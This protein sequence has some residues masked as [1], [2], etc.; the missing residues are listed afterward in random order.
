MDDKLEPIAQRMRESKALV[1][2]NANEIRKENDDPPIGL[3]EKQ[4]VIEAKQTILNFSVCA[5]DGGLLA[6]R[7]VGA[8]ILVRRSVAVN[9]IYSNGLLSPVKYHP[10]KFPDSIVDFKS[11]L[12]EHDALVFR[13]LFR[14]RGEIGLAIEALDIFKPNFLFLDGSIVPLGSDKPGEGSV[15]Y[16]DYEE[17][18]KEYKTLYQK[19][20]TS[21]CQ[22]VGVIKD[23]RG[24]RLVE[25]LADQLM[26]EFP[27]S[28]LCDALL[29]EGER[30]SIMSYSADVKKHQVLKSLGDFSER[31]KLFYLKP[32]SID[33]PLR[34]EFLQNP[35]DKNKS[36]D[37]IASVVLSL[38]SIS[39]AF[40][41]P[42]ALIEADMCAALEPLEMD[43]IKRSLFMMSGGAGKPLRRAERPFR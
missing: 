6:D 23:S 12:D 15:L 36:A 21:G 14:L 34:V 5:V 35:N 19:C 4:I 2:E 32:S 39:K 28:V 3:E 26:G 33:S 17:L 29:H 8:D 38:S 27:D 13:S 1:E 20:E 37:E 22:L 16:S 24:K 11:G 43:K 7:L 31:V 25:I 40:A 9:F 42:A 41:Y 30:T 18:I 10:K